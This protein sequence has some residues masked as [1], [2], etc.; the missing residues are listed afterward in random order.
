MQKI[1]ELN[2][3]PFEFCQ[4]HHFFIRNQQIL[5]YQE[6]QIQIAFRYIISNSFNFFWSIYIDFFYKMVTILIISAKMTTIGILIERYFE[7]KVMTSWLLSMTSTTKFFQVSQIWP[8]FG[9][10]SISMR[11]VITTF[12]LKGFHQKNR[13]SW[14]MAVV[15][16]QLFWTG[17][18]YGLEILQQCRK[19]VKTKSHKFLGANSND[20]RS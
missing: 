18:S 9:N 20:W 1:Y 8:K 15:Q 12:I 3:T 6:I 4:H 5:L 17:T 11:E 16:V 13:I 19:G 14:G 10:S 7:I 2:D